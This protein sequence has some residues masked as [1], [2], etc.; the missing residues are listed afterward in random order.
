MWTTTRVT[1][2]LGIRVPILQA[3][4]AG[5]ATTPE[6]MAAVSN[7]G[8]LGS[9]GAGYLS[10][11]AMREAI[12]R[13]RELTDQPFAV[14]LF[15]PESPREDAVRSA[16]A[17]G[18]MRPY[19]AELGLPEEPSVAA[20]AEP[21][22]EQIAVVL[23]ERVPVFSFTFGIPSAEVLQ[24]LREQGITTIGTA[25]TVREAVLL[26]QSGIDLI[27]AQGGE[28]GGHRGTFLGRPEDALVGTMALVPQIVDGVTL[29]V[30]AAGG[31]M[32]GRGIAAAL[33]LGA[34]AV[35]LGTAFLT[36]AECGIHPAYKA[37]LLTSTEESTSLTKAFSGKPAR[38][39]Q[40]RFLRE[41]EPHQHAL[42]DYPIQNALTR[43]I[44]QAAAKQNNP[45]FLSLWAGQGSRLTRQETAAELMSRLIEQTRQTLQ[46]RR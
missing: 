41:M 20:Y 23:E 6:L 32:D 42:P 35:Q 33:M 44:R 16:A 30:I 40:N 9:L 27:H 2:K 34:E 5:G 36:T 39:L 7:A 12:R 1:E 19:R 13:I 28:A 25:T 4:M 18:L 38:G 3:P 43:D 24:Q 37:A 21:F 26:E 17:N 46:T 15:V 31:I 10:A 8:G 14:N 11:A 45:D 29:P 22:A